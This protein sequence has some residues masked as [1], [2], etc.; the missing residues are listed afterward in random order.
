VALF[1]GVEGGFEVFVLAHCF[2]CSVMRVGL[3]GGAMGT[4]GAVVRL[5]VG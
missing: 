1:L 3:G 5:V 2:E 4:W